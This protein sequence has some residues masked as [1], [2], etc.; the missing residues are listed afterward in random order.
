M[1]ASILFVLLL[2]ATSNAHSIFQGPI[3]VYLA[4][5]S[6]AASSGTTG[7]SWF[8]VA[9]DGLS[10]GVW[11]VDNMISNSGWSYFIMPSCITPGNYLMRVEIIALHS[12]ILPEKAEFYLSCAQIN[13]I[14][15]GTFSPNYTVSFP[16]AYSVE[17]PDLHLDIYDN[18]GIPN[19]GGNTYYPPVLQSSA[20]LQVPILDTAA[21]RSLEGV[22][23]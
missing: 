10:E 13:V 17:D 18:N 11:G 2:A 14:G 12:A 6:N 4:E 9:S 7:L 8:K 23:Q 3:Q 20:A 5:V 1:K 15:S 21:L 16:G 22:V 19:N